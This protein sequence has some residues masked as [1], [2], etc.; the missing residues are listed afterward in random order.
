MDNGDPRLAHIRSRVLTKTLDG[1]DSHGTSRE[2]TKHGMGVFCTICPTS[3]GKKSRAMKEFEN[4]MQG[5]ENSGL[6]C[7]PVRS[8]VSTSF[9]VLHLLW[10]AL[11]IYR[12]NLV[13]LA[14]FA[15]SS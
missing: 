12:L 10:S 9:M 3:Q 13:Q 8:N 14:H 7:I 4:L 15:C 1:R 6:A 11:Y 5:S 2:M